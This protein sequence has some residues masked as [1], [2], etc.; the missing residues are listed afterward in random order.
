MPTTT[1][2]NA[3][4]PRLGLLQSGHG[5]PCTFPTDAA[6]LRDS[7]GP[8][9][10]SVDVDSRGDA[11]LTNLIVGKLPDLCGAFPGLKK[12]RLLGL[13]KM[14]QFT[15]PAWLSKCTK[16]EEFILGS[17]NLVGKMVSVPASCLGYCELCAGRSFGRLL[18]ANQRSVL[19][20]LHKTPVVCRARQV[21]PI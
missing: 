9:T 21:L 13:T 20:F 5:Q 16:L 12:I 14:D 7:F 15:M 1:H 11:E 6:G 17:V 3:G 19:A 2:T 4:C 18:L 10:T 8:D